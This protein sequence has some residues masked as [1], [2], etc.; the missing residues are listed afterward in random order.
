VKVESG[1]E[2]P[3]PK[4]DPKFYIDD[5]SRDEPFLVNVPNKPFAVAPYTL[6]MNEGAH[7]RR[8]RRGPAQR[9]L[10]EVPTAAP[11]ATL[12]SSEDFYR[13]CSRNMTFVRIWNYRGSRIVNT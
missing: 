1:A 6:H 11:G 13:R 7:R 9:K 10:D 12:T 4:I 3:L 2:S 5:V 8:M